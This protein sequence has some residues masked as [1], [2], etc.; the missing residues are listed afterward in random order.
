[1]V[2]VLNGAIIVRLY[3]SSNLFASS[4]TDQ[5]KPYGNSTRILLG[6]VLLFLLCFT[7]RVVYKCFY[8]LS[9]LD[10]A[11]WYSVSPLYKF[12]LVLNSSANFIL[13]C[14]IG[15]EFRTA[16]LRVFSCD[17]LLKK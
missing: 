3:K 10:R 2:L 8:Y 16:F 15:T 1:M 17:E 13:Y 11:D 14:L 6:I 5:D 4:R 9:T 12:G 7:P